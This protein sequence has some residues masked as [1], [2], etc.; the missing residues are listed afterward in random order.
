MSGSL[1]YAD[2]VRLH[3]GNGRALTAWTELWAVSLRPLRSR[4]RIGQCSER[5]AGTLRPAMSR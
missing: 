5:Q 3:G 4:T 1:R 2:A